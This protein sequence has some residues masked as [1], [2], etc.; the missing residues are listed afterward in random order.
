MAQI[1]KNVFIAVLFLTL[2]AS[3]SYCETMG[4]DDL[5]KQYS[6]ATA[7]QRSQ[8]E[9]SSIYKMISVS[10]KVKDVIDWAAFDERTDTS[11]QYYKV[12]TEMQTLKPS[13]S[14]SVVIIYK[15]KAK[16]EQLAKGQEIKVDGTLIRIVD[17]LT[18]FS[19][20]VYAEDLT[21]EDKAM[22]DSSTLR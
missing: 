21:D 3:F 13:I 5:I 19:V 14:C 4:I 12:V 18:F 8:I 11:G 20:W 1:M 22:L 15:D 9:A 10:G 7:V 17:E 2:T 16:V 6:V